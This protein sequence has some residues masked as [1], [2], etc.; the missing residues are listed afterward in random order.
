M[1]DQQET[2]DRMRNAEGEIIDGATVLHELFALRAH[3]DGC[4]S[5]VR[6]SAT[7]NAD[8]L[9]WS[10]ADIS[11]RLA[12]VSARTEVLLGCDVSG[13]YGAAARSKMQTA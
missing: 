8:S 7:E 4:L 2:G 11:S 1:A 13:S 6:A 3:V 10:L 9:E 5:M 12:T